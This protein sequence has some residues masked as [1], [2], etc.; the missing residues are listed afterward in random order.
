MKTRRNFIQHSGLLIL[1]SAAVL[2][3][4]QDAQAAAQQ[5]KLTMIID[6]NRCTGCQSCVVACKGYT[7]T[8]PGKFNT[9]L[10]TMEK[11]NT[12][13][14]VIFTPIQCNQCDT[15][16][17]IPACPVEATFKLANGIVVTDW[18]KCQ[19]TGDCITA[20]PYEARFADPRYGEKVDKCD[21]CLNRVVKGLEPACVEACSSGA[22]M[23]G[24]LHNPKGEFASYVQNHPLATRKPEEQTEPNV[25]YKKAGHGL[26]E[27]I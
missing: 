22:R 15:P 27:L 7:R 18:D 6:L 10:I 14:Q 16:P 1:G 26:E 17:C 21:F 20:C 13:A 4:G 25:L 24:D 8:T 2:T 5:P 9:R 3:G 19:S 23:F 11:D 12:P